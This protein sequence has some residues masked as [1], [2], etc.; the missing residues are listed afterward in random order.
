LGNLSESFASRKILGGTFNALLM[1]AGIVV[2]TAGVFN[3]VAVIPPL[4]F[5]IF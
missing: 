3:I 1:A 5:N 2:S 4:L